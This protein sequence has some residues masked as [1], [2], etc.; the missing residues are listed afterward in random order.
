[1]DN[2]IFGNNLFGRIV[3]Y[4]T[5]ASCTDNWGYHW[6][7]F[8]EISDPSIFAPT[9]NSSVRPKH[10]SSRESWVRLAAAMAAI[11]LYPCPDMC[12][13][14]SEVCGDSVDMSSLSA[15]IPT[16]PGTRPTLAKY[17]SH[18]SVSKYWYSLA[19]PGQCCQCWH[20]LGMKNPTQDM[21]NFFILM[22]KLISPKLSISFKH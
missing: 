22:P 15:L 1:M 16:E 3:I 6:S 5:M 9:R 20:H 12:S 18:Y 19:C 14:D 13:V 11:S 21:E 17:C 7:I 10:R 4:P 8:T 2:P